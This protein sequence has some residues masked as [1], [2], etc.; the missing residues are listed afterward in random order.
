MSST[1]TSIHWSCKRRA[2]PVVLEADFLR[3]G[4]LE[5]ELLPMLSGRDAILDFSASLPESL[6]V[7]FVSAS[8]RIKSSTMS[9][10]ARCTLFARGGAPN[11]AILHAGFAADRRNSRGYERAK[12]SSDFTSFSA[13]SSMRS[14]ARYLVRASPWAQVLSGTPGE[15]RCAVTSSRMRR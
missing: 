4:L 13:V 8:R 10:F 14:A 9:G 6:F 15:F 2:M 3:P 1:E 7:Q 12:S 5:P 11:G